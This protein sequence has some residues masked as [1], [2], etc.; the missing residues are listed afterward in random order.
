MIHLR[1]AFPTILLTS[2]LVGVLDA[3][4]AIVVYSA[5]PIRMFQFIASGVIGKEAF[6]GGMV[7]AGWGVLFHFF[8]AFFWTAVYFILYPVLNLRTIHKFVS[9]LLYGIII[10]LGMNM[11]VLPISHGAPREI[12]VSSITGIVILIVAVGL[13]IAWMVNR[14]YA[15]K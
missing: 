5:N 10:W 8:I 11:I 15:P 12:T 9:G 3:L 7:S 14:Y 6:A 13:P 1:K 2:L 4:A